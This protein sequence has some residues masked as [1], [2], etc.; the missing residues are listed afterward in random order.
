VAQSSKISFINALFEELLIQSIKICS[1]GESGFTYSI[2]VISNMEDRVLFEE[3]GGMTQLFSALI[4]KGKVFA[5]TLS[6]FRLLQHLRQKHFFATHGTA[7][8][9]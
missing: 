9:C 1:S 7:V 4:A 6:A 5:T 3:C 2:F 8:A